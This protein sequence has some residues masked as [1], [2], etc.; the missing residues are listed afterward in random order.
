MCVPLGRTQALKMTSRYL[1]VLRY[2]IMV[3]DGTCKQRNQA[4]TINICLQI[5]GDWVIS[6]VM[7]SIILPRIMSTCIRGVYLKINSMISQ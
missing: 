5:L 6:T 3:I 4:S 1:V 7:S 2:A